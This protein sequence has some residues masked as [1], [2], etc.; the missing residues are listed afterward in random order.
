MT[1]WNGRRVMAMSD[2]PLVEHERVSQ[3]EYGLLVAAR[4]QTV[5]RELRKWER[6]GWIHIEYGGIRVLNR[7]ALE[8][9]V[10]TTS[11]Y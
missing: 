2:G 7:G 4:R 10:E 3:E 6:A 8:R 9:L 1:A 11:G 5:N